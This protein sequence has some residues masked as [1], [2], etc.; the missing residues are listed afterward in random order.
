MP[1]VSPPFNKKSQSE[2]KSDLANRPYTSIQLLD[3]MQ[4]APDNQIKTLFIIHFLHIIKDETLI[5]AIIQHCRDKHPE[6]P[7]H[8][9][10]YEETYLNLALASLSKGSK[11]GMYLSYINALT[12]K[13][14]DTNTPLS[15]PVLNQLTLLMLKGDLDAPLCETLFTFLITPR[16]QEALLPYCKVIQSIG[17]LGGETHYLQVI[18]LCEWA[19]KKMGEDHL[20]ASS[21]QKALQE[22]RLELELSQNTGF[23]S[24]LFGHFK[25]CY[26]YGWS[27]FFSPNLPTYVA[28]ASEELLNPIVNKPLPTDDDLQKVDALIETTFEYAR[29]WR[30]D[31]WT[32]IN[33]IPHIANRF[34]LMNMLL[35][36]QFY[37]EIRAFFESRF[38]ETIE[39]TPLTN[40]SLTVDISTEQSDK[41]ID[42]LD[43][44]LKASAAVEEESVKNPSLTTLVNSANEYIGYASNAVE[45]LLVN[46]DG[47]WDN[48]ASYWSTQFF[49]PSPAN[50]TANIEDNKTQKPNITPKEMRL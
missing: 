35:E 25:R 45:D 24:Q 9:L 31:D 7:I 40:A 4:K 43:E 15:P 37:P 17:Q 22:A 33:Q 19:L 5:S 32:Q 8:R 29:D 49:T 23:F 47:L 13:L 10:D 20:E 50:C 26:T 18:D 2:I 16:P 14:L 12:T 41:P 36:T 39:A 21:I 34:H 27:G 3:L 30:L 44:F 28:L 46:V 48:A 11:K 42:A 38:N 1:K 6:H